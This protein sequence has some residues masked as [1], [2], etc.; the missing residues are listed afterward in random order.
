[1]FLA[2]FAGGASA[3]TDPA[4]LHLRVIQGEGAVYSAAGRAT[5]GVV[6]QVTDETGKPVAD[7][8]VSFRLPDQGPT[9]EF[10]SGG[11]AE[12]VKTSADGRAEVWGMQWGKQTG[13]LEM[14]ITAAKGET[15]G[16]VVCPLYLSD[17]PV[18][19]SSQ[20]RDAA[21]VHKIS[22]SKRKLWIGI[23][24]AAGASLAVAGVA[25]GNPAAGTSAPAASTL[26]T[27]GAPTI[28]ITRP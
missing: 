27:I 28:S 6:V 15:R 1:L 14:K 21:P 17:A 19:K 20:D 2:V 4:V 7:A 26:P 9:G 22:H 3:E 24:L 23:A 12:I 10:S 25:K 11:K 13:S 16:G 18:L 8:A 5:R